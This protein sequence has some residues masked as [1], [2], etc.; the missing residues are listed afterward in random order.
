[1]PRESCETESNGPWPYLHLLTH[2]CSPC[3]V[4]TFGCPVPQCPPAQ[5]VEKQW[6][7]LRLVGGQDVS[8]RKFGNGVGRGG[9]LRLDLG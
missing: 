7:M 4:P 5:V 1:M 8:S 9:S 3:A 6:Q 2:N